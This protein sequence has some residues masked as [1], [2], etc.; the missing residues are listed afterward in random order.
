MKHVTP[1][2]K[3]SIAGNGS[4]KGVAPNPKW[5]RLLSRAV[6]E[7]GVFHVVL[8]LSVFSTLLS[9]ILSET[10]YLFWGEPEQEALK[11][12]PL[13][14]PLFVG[15]PFFALLCVALRTLGQTQIQ[16]KATH[17]KLEQLAYTDPLTNL[18][19]RRSFTI[20]AQREIARAART[21]TELMFLMMDL[22]RFKA[23][24]DTY[25]HAAG[26]DVI[27]SFAD[28][29]R[30]HFRETDIVGRLGGEEFGA[31]LIS[32]NLNGVRTRAETFRKQVENQPVTG[33]RGDIHITVS[34]GISVYE[35]GADS[36][37]TLMTRAD[38]ALYEA[39]QN[40]RNRI[41]AHS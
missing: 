17:D 39:K 16:L 24:N 41:V 22:D 28:L 27:K 11:A 26:D 5:V 12:L 6:V 37:E 7:R 40:G 1:E 38:D 3:K 34:I 32:E 30:H 14:I 31:L 23:I 29:C 19:N 10:M 9:L 33:E 15:P 21:G 36:L 2:G 8:I 25:G 20:A 4:G 35:Q 13:L 18:M